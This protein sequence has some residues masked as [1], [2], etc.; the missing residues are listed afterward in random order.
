MYTTA[1]TLRSFIASLTEARPRALTWSPSSKPGVSRRL[2]VN[3]AALR[4]ARRGRRDSGWKGADAATRSLRTELRVEL[5]PAPCLP[6]KT[7]V[8]S[9]LPLARSVLSTSIR[10]CCV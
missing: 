2:R 4:P 7:T 9:V 1:S 8:I 10:L 3:P 5:L 6:T